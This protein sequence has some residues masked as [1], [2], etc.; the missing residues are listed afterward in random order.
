MSVVLTNLAT[1]VAGLYV[2]SIGWHY[3]YPRSWFVPGLVMAALH[4]SAN[5]INAVLVNATAGYEAT[6]TVQLT[7]LWCSMPRLTWST[8]LLAVLR[9]FRKTTVYTVASCL[10]AEIILQALSAVPMIQTINY[11]REHSFYSQGMA[12]LG[13]APSA[14]YMYAGAAIWLVVIIVTSVL[15]LQAAR[16][17]IAQPESQTRQPSAPTV[18]RELMAPFNDQLGGFEQRLAHYWL[19]GSQDLE[20]ERPLVHGRGQ[21]YVNHGT[22]PTKGCDTCRTRTRTVRVTLITLTSMLLLWV[23]QWMFWAGF[24]DISSDE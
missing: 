9:P 24:I 23:A 4:I 5:W 6:S 8:V 12:R 10:F 1:L 19:D 15:L 7:L 13:A 18:A 17:V 3:A 16:G 20:E 2:R 14:Q 21:I 11:G 22:F